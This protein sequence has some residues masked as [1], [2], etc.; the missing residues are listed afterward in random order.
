M[1]S[2]KAMQQAAHSMI[3]V[4][5]W[6]SLDRTSLILPIIS[7]VMGRRILA[8]WVTAWHFLIS[9]RTCWSRGVSWRLKWLCSPTETWWYLTAARY[10]FMVAYE[11]FIAARR[12]EKST[13]VASVVGTGWT[14]ALVHKLMNFCCPALYVSWWM[15]LVHLWRIS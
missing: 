13:D 2:K 7:R 3:F 5:D 6:G 11:M 14:F 10:I 1:N 4:K 9:R 8:G 15:R 12:V